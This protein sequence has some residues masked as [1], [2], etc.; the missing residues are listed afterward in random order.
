MVTPTPE[1]TQ[2]PPEDVKAERALLGAI[3]LESN[4]AAV[5]NEIV[6]LVA[7]DDFTRWEHRLAARAI[8]E[9]HKSGE[10][11]DYVTVQGALKWEPGEHGWPESAGDPGVF[12]L[13][14]MAEVPTTLGAVSYAKR[15]RGTA[16]LRGIIHAANAA[17]RSALLADP[18]KAED[19]VAKALEPFERLLHD[20][21]G[22]K[23]LSSQEVATH[24]YG[25][26]S[27][28]MDG[29]ES[30]IGFATGFSDIDRFT[31]YQPGE[32]WYVA[33]RRSAG[34]TAF[35]QTLNDML[36]GRGIPTLLVSIEQPLPQ[37]LD[38]TVAAATGID[39][40]RLARG[41]IDPSEFSHVSQQLER[42]AKRPAYYIEDGAMDTTRLNAQVQIAVARWGVRVVFVDYV[43]LL[44]D[45]EGDSKVEQVGN[46]SRKLKL[47]A[48]RH[49]VTIV[50]ASQTNKTGDLRWA[51]ELE[52]DA[53]VII[54]IEREMDST[55]AKIIL[56]K[57]RN[58][59]APVETMMYFQKQTARFSQSSSAAEPLE[60]RTYA[61]EPAEVRPPGIRQE[62][63]W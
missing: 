38:R 56:E 22:S 41:K 33:A 60:R 43:Q 25:T 58:G 31:A 32:I 20:R 7:P 14:V 50:A 39:S 12:L 34:K 49:N 1:F 18:S 8:W 46:I 27:S 47:I 9:L 16:I 19:A 13:E 45:R 2:P 5:L 10:R 23:I 63:P 62:I 15:V 48:A 3:M 4:G 57:N 55:Q 6:A 36:S 30:V 51:Q 53:S 40:M 29:D 59:L 42:L 54:K 26:L 24:Y 61:P 21:G 35:L 37:L 52:Q 11:I 17:A 28:R 44:T